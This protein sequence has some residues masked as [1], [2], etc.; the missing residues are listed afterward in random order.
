M[1]APAVPPEPPG[2]TPQELH[3]E[4]AAQVAR[5]RRAYPAGMDPTQTREELCNT[6]L[7]F[8][9]D[10]FTLLERISVGMGDALADMDERLD[11]VEAQVG[12]TETQ[13]VGEDAERLLAYVDGTTELMKQILASSPPPDETMAVRL[14]T[15]LALGAEC[16]EIVDDGTMVVDGLPSAG[17]EEG[18]GEP[19][20]PDEDEP[21]AD[22]QEPTKTRH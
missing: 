15:L 6:V 1:T 21:A 7:P 3:A 22:A 12:E 8:V 2:S 20:E 14:R 19:N 17:G 11:A 4:I 18:S 5:I 16:R 10:V 13:I 9:Q